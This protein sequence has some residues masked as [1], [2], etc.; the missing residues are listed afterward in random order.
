MRTRSKLLLAGLTATAVF[1]LAVS[2]AS[3][4]RFEA[5]NEH[6]LAIWPALK[7]SGGFS[8]VECPVTLEGNYHSRII[9]K[10]SGQLIGFVTSAEV[11]ASACTG[12]SATVLHANL[13]WHLR[14]DRWAGTLPNISSIR[15]QL[16]GG[17]FR[18]DEGI[19][20]C[21]SITRAGEPGFGTIAVVSGAARTIAAEGTISCEGING[22]FSGTGEVFVQRSTTRILIRLVQ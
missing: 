4:R 11:R 20:T 7:F 17:E 19:F 21:L 12:G 13:P 3:A 9:S 22:T 10:V 1:S 5:S 8:P 18:I 14:F 6:Y 16:V 15:Q 2:S